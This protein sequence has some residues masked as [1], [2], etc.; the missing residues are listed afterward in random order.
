[1]KQTIHPSILYFGTP[2]V[3]LSTRNADGTANLA[4]FSSVF[5]LGSRAV[6]GLN[7]RSQTVKN[8]RRTGEAVINLPSDQE[9]DAVDR[10]AL[11][12]G[13]DP[14]PSYKAARGY[15]YEGDKF[16]AAK[17][18]PGPTACVDVPSIAEF[19]VHLE[20]TLGAEHPMDEGLSLFVLEVCRVAVEQELVAEGSDHRIDPDR[21]RP[22]IMSF[23]QFYGLAPGRVRS[24]VLASIPE[25]AYR[26]EAVR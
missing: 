23:Q 11:T 18:S 21:W 13:A 19:P 2:V 14:V 4:P 22:L 3:V 6:L 8:L 5:W 10:L 1:M 26:K 25:D 7:T 20:A 9:A 12:T 24:S 16:G 17:V 15:R